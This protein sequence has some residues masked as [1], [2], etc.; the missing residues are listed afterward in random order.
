MWLLPVLFALALVLT[1]LC[2]PWPVLSV[3]A[4]VP[5]CLARYV[6]WVA[7]SLAALPFHGADFTSPAMVAWLVLVYLLLAVCV[8]SRQRR[9]KYIVAALVAAVTGLSA[10]ALPALTAYDGA[11]TVVAVDVGQGAATLLSSGGETALV[12][13]GSLYWSRGPGNAV[14]DAMDSYGWESLDYVA[15]THYHQDHAGGLGELLARV[16]VGRLLLPVLHEEDD[17][18]LQSRVL[19]LAEE[20]GVPVTY[21]ETE[22]EIPLGEATITVYPPVSQGDVNEEGLTVL[23]T[24]GDFDVLITGDMGSST[25]ELLVE[26]YDLPDIEVLMVGHHGS[27]Y[28][29]SDTLLEAVT[30]EIGIISVGENRYGHPTEETMDRLREHGVAL[31]RTDTQGN[32]TIRVRD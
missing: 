19:A 15:L 14:A 26:E 16:S 11:L 25:E 27:K 17:A 5:A 12:D 22:E 31:Y 21:V 9:R 7:R 6:L 23:C 28:A 13:C 30:P 32:I 8:I 29:T 1:V 24:A 20:Y 18:A 2:I 10:H 4:P 3:L